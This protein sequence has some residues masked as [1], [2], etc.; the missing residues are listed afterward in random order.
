MDCAV[1]LQTFPEKAG[2]GAAVSR[3]AAPGNRCGEK[4]RQNIYSG[5]EDRQDRCGG[6]DRWK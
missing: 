2:A 1:L 3:F 4:N 5:K 6:N